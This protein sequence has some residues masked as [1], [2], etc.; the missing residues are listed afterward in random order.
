MDLPGRR[1]IHTLEL[2]KGLAAARRSEAAAPDRWSSGNYRGNV[3]WEWEKAGQQ[4]FLG[5]TPT[6]FRPGSATK[7][8]LSS[9]CLR[10]CRW[11]RDAAGPWDST[12]CPTSTTATPTSASTLE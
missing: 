1:R 5:R 12:A 3:L 10:G 4:R 11:S 9:S 2:R 7:G 8:G 6:L